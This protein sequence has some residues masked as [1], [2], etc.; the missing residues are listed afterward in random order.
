M[1]MMRRKNVRRV[2]LAGFIPLYQGPEERRKMVCQ[3][4]EMAREVSE[5]L[6]LPMEEG[7]C[8]N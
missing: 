7:R 5:G 6:G 4:F 1:K 8:I 3:D 2:I